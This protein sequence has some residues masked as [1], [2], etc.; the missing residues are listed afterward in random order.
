MAIRLNFIVEG[1]TEEAFVNTILRPH[2]A[3]FAVWASARRVMT[4]RKGGIKHS[5]GIV[6]YAH[7][8]SDIG[9]W[10]REDKNQDAHFTTM[11]DLY[12]LPE[13]FPGYADA[14][15][16][17]NPYSR[18]KILEDALAAEIADWRFTPYLQLH[19]FEA[20]LLAEPRQLGTQFSGCDS[21]IERLSQMAAQFDSPEWVNDG[22][23]TAPSKRIIAEIPE[24]AGRKVSAGPIV[25]GQIG[26]PAL[27]AKCRHFGEWLARLEAL[28]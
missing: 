12:H 2:L 14:E 25:A 17:S 15:R 7:A 4:S 27:R 5:G 16:A 19:E 21:E 1:Q 10:L 18:V 11:F 8:R 26:L 3:D 9:R 13:E 6:N 23:S 28:G 20:L 24:Y 22:E